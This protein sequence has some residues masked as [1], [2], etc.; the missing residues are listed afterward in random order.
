MSN[1]NTTINGLAEGISLIEKDKSQDQQSNIDYAAMIYHLQD[2]EDSFEEF[3]EGGDFSVPDYDPE[4]FNEPINFLSTED[5][6][7]YNDWED[8]C[9]I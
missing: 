8:D 9:I 7:I 4:S 3:C 2:D 1:I 6:E 5:E